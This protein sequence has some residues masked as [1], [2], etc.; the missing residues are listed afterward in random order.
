[1]SKQVSRLGDLSVGHG[2]SPPRPSITGSTKTFTDKKPTHRVTDTWAPHPVNGH[3]GPPQTT[4]LG[5]LKNFSDR[6]PIARQGD[7]ISCGDT[8]GVGSIKTFSI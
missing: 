2:S 8:I 1:M 3:P 4:I 5:S 7:L 6:L